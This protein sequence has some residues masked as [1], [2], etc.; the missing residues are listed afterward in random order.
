M[1]HHTADRLRSGLRARRGL[2]ALV[3]ISL[4][5]STVPALFQRFEPGDAVGLFA[6]WP[7]S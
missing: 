1:L 6:P 4:C 2:G 3:A 7:D 5:F